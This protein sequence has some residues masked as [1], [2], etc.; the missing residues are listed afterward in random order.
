MTISAA[1]YASVIVLSVILGIIYLYFIVKHNDEDGWRAERII[2]FAVPIAFVMGRISYVILNFE[3]FRGNLGAIFMFWEGGISFPIAIISFFILV[4]CY[5]EVHA[6]KAML[7]WDIFIIPIIFAVSIHEL[8]L[9]FLF[10]ITNDF[11]T[12]TLPHIIPEVGQITLSP[13]GFFEREFL[14]NTALIEG[15]FTIILAIF[16]TK[17]RNYD[18]GAIFF[19]GASLFFLIRFISAFFYIISIP[20]LFSFSHTILF[21]IFMTFMLLFLFTVKTQR[22]QK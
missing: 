21:I 7:W 9:H 3:E 5:S 18:N 15:I 20:M 14:Q 16:L 19:L 10:D 1:F 6:L 8:L 12:E 13:I 11:F 22:G 2:L 4:F 17:K